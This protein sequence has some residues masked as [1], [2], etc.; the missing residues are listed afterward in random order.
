MGRDDFFPHDDKE[1]T[2]ENLQDG[3]QEGAQGGESHEYDPNTWHDE[4]VDDFADSP[5]EVQAAETYA[6]DQGDEFQQLPEDEALHDTHDDDMDVHETYADDGASGEMPAPAAQSSSLMRYLPLAGGVL[7]ILGIGYFGW[8]QMSGMLAARTE[9]TPP[10]QMAD[11]NNTLP[12]PAEMAQAQPPAPQ[13]QAELQ[14]APPVEQP[15]V[16]QQMI[17]PDANG[18]APPMAPAPTPPAPTPLGNG[19]PP[20]PASA[21]A[22]LANNEPPQKII[23]EPMP[24]EAPGAPPVLSAPPVNAPTPVAPAPVA[25]NDSARVSELTQQID[26]MKANEAKLN[27]QISSLQAKA[28]NAPDSAQSQNTIKELNDKVADLQRQLSQKEAAPAPSSS[29]EPVAS[30]SETPKKSRAFRPMHERK[31]GRTASSARTRSRDTEAVLL[32]RAENERLRGSGSV[33]T[34][35]PTPVYTPSASDS[36]MPV[37][38]APVA[39]PAASAPVQMQANWILRSAQPGSA[40]LSLGGSNNLRRVAPGDKVQGLGTITAIRQVAGRWLVEGT[41]GSVQ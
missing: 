21:P 5:E 13:Q 40:W 8:Q 10:A 32:Q 17:P 18:V 12:P 33:R 41:M 11:A 35:A 1:Q 37:A 19:A 36:P 15:P 9:E 22:P 6:E 24:A 29:P 16:G 7:A 34:A 28:A 26:S 25:A 27:E 2:D 20:A 23:S 38:P 14:N 39:N 31:S 30:T 3:A 4:P